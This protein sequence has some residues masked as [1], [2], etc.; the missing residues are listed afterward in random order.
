MHLILQVTNKC[1]SESELAIT[2]QIS[3]TGQ[4]QTRITDLH[5][6]LNLEGLCTVSCLGTALCKEGMTVLCLQ[7]PSKLTL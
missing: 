4:L 6:A 5:H 7:Q 1:R 2:L 3:V